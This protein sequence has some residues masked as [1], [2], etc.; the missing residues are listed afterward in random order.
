M[1]SDKT[2]HVFLKKMELEWGLEGLHDFGRHTGREKYFWQR[3]SK[4]Y[5]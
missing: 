4:E 2:V 1:P 5:T 3:W